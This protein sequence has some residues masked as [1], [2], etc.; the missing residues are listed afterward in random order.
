MFEQV[1]CNKKQLRALLENKSY[2]T[3]SKLDDIAVRMHADSP[4][5]LHLVSSKG[6]EECKRRKAFLGEDFDNNGNPL[7]Q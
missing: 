2:T 5:W 1:S 7:N 3:W 4:E 6:I